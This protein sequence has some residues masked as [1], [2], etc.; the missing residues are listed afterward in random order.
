MESIEYEKVIRIEV[1]TWNINSS[2][3]SYILIQ[4]KNSN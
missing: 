3:N 1:L 4:I 2:Y